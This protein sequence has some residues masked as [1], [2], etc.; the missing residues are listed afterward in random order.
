MRGRPSTRL[1]VGSVFENLPAAPGRHQ[2]VASS[3]TEPQG[4]ARGGRGPDPPTHTRSESRFKAFTQNKLF[5]CT[6]LVSVVFNLCL[7][8]LVTRETASGLPQR[9]PAAS[10]PGPYPAPS[11]RAQG[12]PTGR[13]PVSRK[14]SP[15]AVTGSPLHRELRTL[16]SARGSPSRHRRP[17][18][19]LWSMQL[20]AAPPQKLVLGS[21]CVREASIHAGKGAAARSAQARAG[22]LQACS[23]M[24]PA[25]PHPPTRPCL[26]KQSHR[27]GCPFVTL[28]PAL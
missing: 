6:C 10:R 16:G 1:R 14:T 4:A 24:A 9:A 21:A 19:R 11:A 26:R 23:V 13:S 7:Y 2:T 28:C 22:S 3:P 5:I 12:S 27:V 17:L 8:I 25:S 15:P 18:P 20:P